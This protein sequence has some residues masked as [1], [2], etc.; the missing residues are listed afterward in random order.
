MSIDRP[1]FRLLRLRAGFRAPALHALA[2]FLSALSLCLPGRA[3]S[4]AALVPGVTHVCRPVPDSI[5]IDGILDEPQWKGLDTLRLALNN[6]PAGGM[7]TVETKVLVAWSRTRLYVAFIADGKNV[8]GTITRHD[9]AL[10]DQDVVEMF[11]DPDGDGKDYIE[12]E[13]NC[14]NTSLD[15]FFT[16]PRQG[17]NTAWTAEGMQNAVKVRG[18]ANNASDTDTGMVAEISLPW[19]ALKQWSKG[20]LPPKA[21]DSLALNFYR[22]NYPSPNAPELIAWSP[23]DAADFHR[24]DKFGAL[25]FSSTPVTSVLPMGAAHGSFPATRALPRRADGR[26]A[27]RGNA[28]LILFRTPVPTR[29]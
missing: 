14:L 1:R 3:C 8:K 18:T 28:G 2:L 6:A 4:A 9:G 22:I 11:I 25:I 5:K 29:P 19:T 24:P 10:Y 17:D 13:W 27:D 7:P 26:A 12:L 20:A 15:Y 16:A 23:T 21:G